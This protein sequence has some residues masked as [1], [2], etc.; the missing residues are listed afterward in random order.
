MWI[1]CGVTWS[2]WLRAT[3]Y[4]ASRGK[5]KKLLSMMKQ[6]TQIASLL[7]KSD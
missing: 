3:C 5:M 7:V 1:M 4:W 6:R 2:T